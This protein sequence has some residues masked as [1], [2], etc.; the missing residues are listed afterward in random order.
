MAGLRAARWPEDRQ[1][2]PHPATWL[3]QGRWDDEAPP[4]RPRDED[5]IP[6]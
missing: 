1:F 2:I 6:L 3:N 4:S 5:L